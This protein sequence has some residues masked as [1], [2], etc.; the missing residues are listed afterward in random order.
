[1]NGKIITAKEAKQ[2]TIH[3]VS[4]MMR[5]SENIEYLAN[6]GKFRYCLWG[7]ISQRTKTQL[8]KLGYTVT[9][10]DGFGLDII[11]WK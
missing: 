2:I 6:R 8:E 1:M 4:K 7:P 9:R 10:S 5:I 11:S 3:C